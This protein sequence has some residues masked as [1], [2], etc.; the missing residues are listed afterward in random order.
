M[1]KALV[2]V[3]SPSKANTIK[4][5]FESGYKIVALVGFK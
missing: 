1:S 4:K 3:E 2:V 5:F